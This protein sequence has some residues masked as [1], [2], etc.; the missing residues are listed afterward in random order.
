MCGAPSNEVPNGSYH[1]IPDHMVYPI[2][3]KFLIYSSCIVPVTVYSE[4]DDDDSDVLDDSGDVVD[5]DDDVSDGPDVIADDDDEEV[6]CNALIS[7][8]IAFLRRSDCTTFD[9]CSV[10]PSS[11]TPN[12]LG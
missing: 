7:V 5:D 6:L 11:N 12:G 10:P 9:A 8:L 3:R 2:V 1:S 4:D